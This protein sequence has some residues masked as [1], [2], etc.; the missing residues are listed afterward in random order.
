MS[1]LL[2]VI[3]SR[4]SVRVF[5]QDPVPHDMVLKVLEAE[6]RA[7]TAG[8]GEQWFFVVVKVEKKKAIHRLLLEAHRKYA[9]EVLKEPMSSEKVEKWVREMESGM[10]MAP[11]YIAAYLDMR[12]R[13]HKEE[14]YEFERLMAIQSLAAAVENMLLAAHALG[15][16]AVWLGVPLLSKERF[17]EILQPPPGCELQAIIALGY[18]AETL[19][20][21]GRKKKISEIVKVT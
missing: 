5:K 8:G 21:R 3:G 11:V 16:G 7:P 18:L 10:Y 12:E 6:I 14:Y 4:T 15:L 17:D 19:A 13:F 1:E 2:S 20:P 9:T